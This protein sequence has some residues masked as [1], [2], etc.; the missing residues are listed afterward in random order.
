VISD[1]QAWLRDDVGTC[2]EAIS[3][4]STKKRTKDYSPPV[5]KKLIVFLDDLNMPK[6][7]VR[8]SAAHIALLSSSSSARIVY[9][10][11]ETQLEAL[12]GGSNSSVTFRHGSGCVQNSVILI[13]YPTLYWRLQWH[14]LYI[15]G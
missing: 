3:R 13:L 12:P 2:N 10:I 4:D 6:V 8:R 5:G 9:M 15:V 11:E 7:D 14:R 1:R